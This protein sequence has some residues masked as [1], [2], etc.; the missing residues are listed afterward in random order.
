V[1][2]AVR[3][4]ARAP[5]NRPAGPAIDTIQAL[6][7]GVAAL[8][9]EFVKSTVAIVL[10]WSIGLSARPVAEAAPM[11]AFRS[12]SYDVSLKPDFATGVL[13]GVERL[14]FQSLSDGLDALSFTTN[15]LAVNATLDG[16]AGVTVT[17]EGDRRIFHLPRRLAKGE[18]ATLVTSFAGRPRRDVVFTAD[19]IHTGFFTCEMMI[20]DVDRPDD[21]ARLQLALTLPTGMDAAAPGKLV[22][23]A[24]AGPGLETWRWR[25]DRPYPSYLY[26]FAAGRYARAKLPGRSSLWVLYASKT[27]ERVQ[28]MFVDTARMIA[29][30]ESRAGVKLPERSYTQ[31]LV[32]RAG[33]QEDASLSMI[34]MRSIEP[35]L[36]DRHEDW[37]VAHELAHQWWGNL[38]TCSD[39]TELWLNEGLTTFMVAAYKEQRWGRAAYDRE[40]AI[41]QADWDAAKKAGTD[42]PLS[43]QGTYPSLHAKRLIAYGKSVVF[44]DELRS[45][46][47]EKAFWRGV[48]LYTQANAGRSVT[49][50]DLQRA[51]ETASD[52]DL[53]A[54]FN[55]WVYGN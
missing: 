40:I 33:D 32:A 53:S 20:C 50:K 15:P 12:L 42:E 4:K 7:C 47:G 16:Q 36:S 22:S 17:T 13:S 45:E 39:W 23:H 35:I 34:E 41:H 5:C 18:R 44:L 24:P 25:E 30:Y 54:T 55:T 10:A 46:L 38:V 2:Q 9:G 19:E 3:A 21:R 8:Q 52:R 14:R 28:D 1:I 6:Q 29:F 51:L 31:V 48:R 49:A 11:S 26:G 43:W 37:I 27:P